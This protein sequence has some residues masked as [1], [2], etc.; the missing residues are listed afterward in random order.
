MKTAEKKMSPLDFYQKAVAESDAALEDWNG[1]FQAGTEAKKESKTSAE[2]GEKTTAKNGLGDFVSKQI[3]EEVE[4]KKKEIKTEQEKPPVRKTK[5]RKVGVYSDGEI[6]DDARE[7]GKKREYLE[8]M[9]E[10]KKF[11]SESI[12]PEANKAAEEEKKKRMKELEAELEDTRRSYL[13][14]DYEVDQASSWIRKFFGFGQRGQWG[15]YNIQKEFQEAKTKYEGV[16]T[17]YKDERFKEEVKDE[18]SAEALLKF[19]QMDEYLKREEARNQIKIENASWPDNIKKNYIEFIEKYRKLPFG[20]KI[21]IGAGIAAAGFGV[22]AVGGAMAGGAVLAVSRLISMSASFVG[23]KGIFEGYAQ[24]G[25]VKEIEKEKEEILKRSKSEGSEKFDPDLFSKMLDGKIKEIDGRMQKEKQWKTWRAWLAV[26]SGAALSIVG[27]YVGKEIADHFRAESASEDFFPGGEA[28]PS[29]GA[30]DQIKAPAG[31]MAGAVAGQAEN[32]PVEKAVAL[33]VLTVEDS[34]SFQKPLIDYVSNHQAEIYRHHPELKNFN[35][36]QIAHRLYLDFLHENSSNPLVRSLDT[37]YSGAK[38]EFD[39]ASLKIMSCEDTRGTIAR[40]I[41]QVSLGSRDRWLEIKD[42]NFKG[43]GDKLPKGEQVKLVA[44][45]NEYEKY[46]G[47][48][49]KMKSGETFK[50]WAGRIVELVAQKNKV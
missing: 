35:P 28:P 48:G 30:V 47:S 3:E 41:K 17:R 22:S 32:I 25:K 40:V 43:I 4:N 33:E 12:N 42:L 14:K 37:V 6:P 38:I 7:E 50:K 20:K 1:Q 2:T 46:F 36:G 8:K 9:E 18:K 19:L 31:V 5:K 10:K 21:I 11:D 29:E 49:A 16:L 15:D 24:K 26:G 45:F 34:G 39:P 13:D 23:F 44:L 27:R